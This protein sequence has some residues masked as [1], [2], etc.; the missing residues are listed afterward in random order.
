MSPPKIDPRHAAFLRLQSASNQESAQIFLVDLASFQ[1]A[2]LQKAIPISELHS[3]FIKRRSSPKLFADLALKSYKGHTIKKYT[4][5]LWDGVWKLISV[6]LIEKN[7]RPFLVDLYLFINSQEASS[8]QNRE[9][10]LQALRTLL[11]VYGKYFQFK[12]AENTNSFKGTAMWFY[13]PFMQELLRRNLDYPVIYEVLEEV[14]FR[15]LPYDP[16]T[17]YALEYRFGYTHERSEFYSLIL[18]KTDDSSFK[19]LKP[20]FLEALFFIHACNPGL[21]NSYCENKLSGST[22]LVMLSRLFEAYSVPPLLSSYLMQWTEELELKHKPWI[23]HILRGASIRTFPGLPFPVSKAM[24][25]VFGAYIPTRM[26][27]LDTLLATVALV[28]KGID[29]DRAKEYYFRLNRLGDWGLFFEVVPILDKKGIGPREFR[30]VWDYLLSLSDSDRS[31]LNLAKIKSEVLRRKIN[32]W[33][34]EL[35]SDKFQFNTKPLPSAKIRSKTYIHN[36]TERLR[37]QQLRSEK[38]VFR[39]GL[40]QEHCV[41]SYIHDLRKSRSYLF[42]MSTDADSINSEKPLFHP[43]LTIEIVANSI[44]QV[45]GKNNRNPTQEEWV[46]IDKWRVDRNLTI[47]NFI[48]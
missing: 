9:R 38:D 7:M 29:A 47:N 39:E 37:F 33:H 2:N 19:I 11:M 21:L 1:R 34:L 36:S 30:E 43:V 45:R 6:S 25:G 10:V 4:P 27:D 48:K 28:V 13:G 23:S 46:W 31:N 16:T 41:F 15:V 14:S 40:I 22:P 26:E 35:G 12:A 44:V 20:S 24:A 3:I 8:E 5:E 17:V 42:S 18:S 32:L